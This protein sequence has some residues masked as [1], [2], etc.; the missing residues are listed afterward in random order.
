[1]R[2]VAF[3]PTRDC[4]AGYAPAH[5]EITEKLTIPEITLAAHT[6]SK[7]HGLATFVRQDTEWSLEIQSEDDSQLEWLAVKVQDVTIIN[8]YIENKATS[9]TP[10]QSINIPVVNHPCIYAGDFNCHHTEWGYFRSNNGGICLVEWVSSSNL[11][12]T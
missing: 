3:L 5:C 4:E 7:Q 10:D 9:N 8:V 1:M 2:K 11:P 12:L 6:L